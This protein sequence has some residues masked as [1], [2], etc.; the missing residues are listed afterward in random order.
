MSDTF[1][2]MDARIRDLID[3][4][5]PSVYAV[6]ELKMFRVVNEQIQIV[7]TL[8]G[9]AETWSTS[10][11]TTVDGTADYALPLGA[12]S[13]NEYAQI[14]VLKD[15]THGRIVKKADHETI[16]ALRQTG[17]TVMT[18]G[19]PFRFELREATN[20]TLNVRLYPVPDGAYDMDVLYSL[21]PVR[22]TLPTN[23]I[24]FSRD[25]MTA[26]EL[27][28]AARAGRMMTDDERQKRALTEGVIQGFLDDSKIMLSESIR[29]INQLKRSGQQE[30]I[31]G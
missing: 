13:D 6:S 12:A 30:R 23:S 14:V 10:A 9:L 20:Q 2:N 31:P 25:L 19:F 4:S 7:G 27:R 11:F 5:T 16:E 3:D 26:L 29:R 15:A 17:S 24:P 28:C 18:K 1:A 21:L 8:A 22:L